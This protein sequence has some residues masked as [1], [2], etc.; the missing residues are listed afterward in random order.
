MA[1]ALAIAED[2]CKRHPNMRLEKA[3]GQIKHE[4]RRQ[5]VMA[6][7]RA[8]ASP[9]RPAE[10][11]AVARVAANLRELADRLEGRVA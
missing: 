11:S 2:L 5:E 9:L 6:E 4:M 1:D 10:P 7:L 3:L 8:H